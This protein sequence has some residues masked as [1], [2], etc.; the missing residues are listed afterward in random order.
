[1]ETPKNMISTKRR[2]S[3]D[4]DV[5]KEVESYGAPEGSKRQRIYSNYV[6]LMRNLVNEEPTC[7]EYASK[8]KEWI[9]AM[10]KEYQS[11]INNDVWDVVP[12]PKD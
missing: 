2:P 6:E 8:K 5:I 1:M 4:R 12:I 11:L 9:Q 10:I 3:W 7:F